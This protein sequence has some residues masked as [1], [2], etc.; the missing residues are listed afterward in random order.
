MTIDQLDATETTQDRAIAAERNQLMSVK[1]QIIAVGENEEVTLKA[2]KGA[3]AMRRVDDYKVEVFLLSDR[4]LLALVDEQ[5]RPDI[6]ID[7]RQFATDR[8]MLPYVEKTVRTAREV[9]AG[10]DRVT[11]SIKR[12]EYGDPYVD[13]NVLVDEGAESE[14]ELYSRCA[15]EWAS[16]IPP[17]V[18]G[19]IQL[20]TSWAQK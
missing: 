12:D 11:V 16:F 17:Q 7:V 8:G 10:Q 13:I 14:A 18:A 20:S 6:S 3:L 5:E 15:L 4:A 19:A 2:P 9:F 1:T